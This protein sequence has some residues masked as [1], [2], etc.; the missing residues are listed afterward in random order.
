MKP[1][2]DET[3]EEEGCAFRGIGERDSGATG[4]KGKP[5]MPTILHVC[6]CAHLLSVGLYVGLPRCLDIEGFFS[7]FFPRTA[8]IIQQVVGK[9]E[10]RFWDEN[11]FPTRSEEWQ[12]GEETERH[13]PSPFSTQHIPVRDHRLPFSFE[14]CCHREGRTFMSLSVLEDE[15]QITTFVPFTSISLVWLA[16]FFCP[17]HSFHSE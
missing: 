4:Q 11:K 6:R 12:S 17:F 8:V 10:H 14:F 3:Y 15:R 5:W 13:F 2:S 7:F 16:H 9:G 1:A